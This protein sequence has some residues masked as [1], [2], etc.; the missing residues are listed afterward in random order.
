[1][2]PTLI[3]D[4]KATVSLSIS[5]EIGGMA[6]AL[7]TDDASFQRLIKNRY[8][9]F[10]GSSSNSHSEFD[11]DLYEPSEIGRA[12]CRERVWR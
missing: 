9:G 7:R 4:E 1:M 5:I 2:T 12:S 10:V 8:A 11:I 6:I 3:A